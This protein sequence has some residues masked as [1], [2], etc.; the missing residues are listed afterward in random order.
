MFNILEYLLLKMKS[1]F[2]FLEVK[3]LF[4]C[5]YKKLHYIHF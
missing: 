3:I 4:E 5:Y 1:L 2:K